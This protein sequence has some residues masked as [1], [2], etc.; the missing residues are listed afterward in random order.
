[1]SSSR[2]TYPALVELTRTRLL[3]FFREPEALFWVFVFPVLLAV[4]L[5][6]AFRSRPPETLQV[7]VVGE[8]DRAAWTAETLGHAPGLAARRLGPEEA[9]RELRTGRVDILVEP[10]EGAEPRFTYRWDGSRAQ[11][12]TA[13]LAAGDALE[14]ALGRA[15]RA[16]AADQTVSEAGGRY[17]DFLLPGLIGLNLMGS[18][19]W[20]VGFA[21]VQARTRKLLK[22]FAASPMR[23]SDYLLALVLSR[24]IFMVAEVAALL[25]FGRLVFG[26]TVHGSWPALAVVALVGALSFC[27][28]ALL[29]GARPDTIESV[30]GWMNF[31]MLP[32]WLL[33]GSF[34]SY[35]RFP[36]VLQPAIRALPLTA[37]NDA[38]RAVM[39]DGAPLSRSATELA[40]LAAWAVVSFLIALRIFRW[41]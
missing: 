20:G 16:A 29:I 3:E 34:F 27:G 38:L 4:A 11:G 13:R 36:A 21:A 30:T 10:A 24:L 2:A 41:R 7:G 5:G 23:R 39:N 12:R 15:D 9:A 35:E 14:R 8:G 17:I 22:R 37:I 28:I 6:I 19:M 32:M 31:V 33:S 1:M 40:V 25:V 26:I 18:G